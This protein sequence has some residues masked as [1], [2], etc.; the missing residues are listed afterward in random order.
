MR[1]LCVYPAL[2]EYIIHV[3]IFQSMA[4]IAAGVALL[5]GTGRALAQRALG[6]DSDFHCCSV[7]FVTA[8]SNGIQFACIKATALDEGFSNS[9]FASRMTA[10]QSAGVYTIP[11]NRC[12][13]SSNAPKTEA[14]FFWSWAK[15]NITAGGYNLSPALDVEDGLT[16]SYISD[17]GGSISLS[18]W[19]NQWYNDVSNYAAAAGIRIQQLTYV[20]IGIMC[21]LGSGLHGNLWLANPCCSNNP[22]TGNP[23]H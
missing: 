5:F 16:G 15:T 8:A 19:C 12:D 22:A 4:L 1:D 3:S 18:G 11:Y 17:T 9:V 6:M 23:L 10:A 21:D 2:A 20:N 7:N 13:P 14:A